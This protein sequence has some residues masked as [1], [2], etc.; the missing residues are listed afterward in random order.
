MVDDLLSFLDFHGLHKVTLCG[1]SMGGKTAMLFSLLHPERVAQLVVL[2]IA[3]VTYGHSHAP[4]LDELLKINLT[5]LD[6]RG[7]ADRALQSTI[8]DSPT[9]LFLLQSLTGSPGQYSWRINLTVLAEY[10]PSIV[11][12]PELEPSV[13]SSLVASVFIYAANSDYLAD[14]YRSTIEK[15]FSE[16]SYVKID[17]A[18]HWLHVEQPAAVLAA[19]QGFL[20]L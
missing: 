11:S 19:V 6:S 12:F 5:T 13:S 18:G 15:Y 20:N 4:F 9:R 3:P 17:N 16:V 8:P 7:A 10:M 2:D 1:H 14:E